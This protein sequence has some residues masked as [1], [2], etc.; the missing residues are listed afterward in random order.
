MCIHHW[1]F[2]QTKKKKVRT[3]EASSPHV[4]MGQVDVSVLLCGFHKLFHP[5]IREA[6]WA[7][8]WESLRF[9]LELVDQ[10]VVNQLRRSCSSS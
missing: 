3:V 7:G 6:P 1:V 8:C 5:L 2:G 10:P 4:E 9:S